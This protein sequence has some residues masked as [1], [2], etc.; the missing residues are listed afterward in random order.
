M[1]LTLHA[2][3]DADTVRRLLTERGL[4]T[5]RFDGSPVQLFVEPHSA[6]VDPDEL[7]RLP[8]VARVAVA[9]STHPLL[10]SQPREVAV[11]GLSIGGA[12]PPVLMAGPCAVESPAQID[13]LA[14]QLAAVGARFLRG[15]AYKPRTSPYSFSGHGASALQW[16]RRAA[17]RH[18]LYVVTEVLSPDDVDAVAAHAELLQI[19]TRNMQNFALLHAVGKSGKPV[20]LKRGMAATVEE[21]LSAGEHLRAH[22]CPAVI[23]C[24]RGVRGF[25]PSTRN[26]FDIGAIALLAH[27]HRL[28]VVADPS[29]AAGRRDLVLPLGRAA[30]A[31]GAHGLL[32][33]AHHQPGR[34]LSDG[35]QALA[36]ADLTAFG[37]QPPLRALSLHAQNGIAQ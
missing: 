33:E 2:G 26:L 28:P 34:A 14:E 11:A 3:A 4:W 27:V 24:E 35:A 1:I 5:Q 10:D 37:L 8:G 36:P 20:L 25:D 6:A 29:H 15:G 17:D 12:A 18:G 30:L 19:G 21:W 13:E 31:A 32:I 9:P 16:I 23:F 7:R 22:G